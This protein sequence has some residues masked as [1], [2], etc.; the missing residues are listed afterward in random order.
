MTDLVARFIGQ[1]RLILA[2]S[3]VLVLIGIAA[4]AGMIRQEDPSFPYRVGYVLVAYPGA[5]PERVERLVLEP[6]EQE[7]AEIEEIKHMKS[8]VRSGQAAIKIILKDKVYNTDTQWDRVRVAVN[9]ARV[10]FPEGVG[11]A[12]VNDRLVDN[13]SAVVSISGSEDLLVLR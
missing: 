6:L 1:R 4:W 10:K 8:V 5:D 11:P 3:G 2:I 9:R 12:V 7:L 13:A